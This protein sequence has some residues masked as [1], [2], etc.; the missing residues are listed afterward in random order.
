[1][2][3]KAWVKYD[4][5]NSKEGTFV[6]QPLDKGL[7][8]TLGNSLRRVLLSSLEGHGVLGVKIEGVT[9]EFSTIPNVVEDVLEIICNLKG[10]IFNKKTEEEESV[11]ISIN[12]KKKVTGADVICSGETKVINKNHYLFEVTDKTTINMTIYIGSG[13]G[14]QDSQIQNKEDKDVSYIATDTSF[15][16]ILKV[17]H[18][19]EMIRV[20]KELDHDKLTMNV[21]TN[22]II[23]PEDAVNKAVAIMANHLDLFD[24]INEEPEIDD[25]EERELEDL[26]VQTILNMSVDELE[27]SA[28]SSNCLKR[29]GIEKV[30][31]L[32]QKD[33]SELVQ[34]KNFG[35]KSADEINQ[36]LKQYNLALK[37]EIEDDEA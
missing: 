17:N 36:R 1:M 5:I 28:R 27:L 14:Y 13:K 34:I 3:T 7:G 2:T 11:T 10:L 8:I 20:G 25:S 23:K 4:E 19:V 30:E 29:A 26:K 15:S 6:I 22:G 9:H 12:N 32:L 21:L 31:Q 18:D 16:P 37:G 24:K 35:K 33:M